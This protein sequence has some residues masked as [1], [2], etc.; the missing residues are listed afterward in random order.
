MAETLVH[1]CD[2]CNNEHKLC[3]HGAES[4]NL[5]QQFEYLCP[6]TGTNV[7]FELSP[8]SSTVIVDGS[9]IGAVAARPVV[10]VGS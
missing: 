10:S 9:A 4:F 3:L 8:Q 2:A 5:H 1:H 6:N 7:E